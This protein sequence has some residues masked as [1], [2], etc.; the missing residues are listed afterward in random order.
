MSAA[1]HVQA[2]TKNWPIFWHTQAIFDG[3]F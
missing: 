3:R 1:N 2:S